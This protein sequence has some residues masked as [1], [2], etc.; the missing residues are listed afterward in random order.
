MSTGQLNQELPVCTRYSRATHKSPKAKRSPKDKIIETTQTDS[1]VK[2]FAGSIHTVT[3]TAGRPFPTDSLFAA[4]QSPSAFIS[5]PLN[6]SVLVIELNRGQLL[7]IRGGASMSKIAAAK[8]RP[9]LFTAKEFA[10]SKCEILPLT[11]VLAQ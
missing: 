2:I 4:R 8:R 7:V 5:A 1:I 11:A 3:E 10:V 9:G 6:N